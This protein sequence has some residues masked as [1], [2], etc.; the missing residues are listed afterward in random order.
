MCIIN[1]CLNMFRASLCSSSGEQRPCYCIWCVVLVLLDVVGS[2][3]QI[4]MKFDIWKFF[5]SLSGKFKF[6][7]NRTII[8]ATLNGGPATCRKV[9]RPAGMSCDRQEGPAVETTLR[10]SVLY[11]TSLQI[12]T[13]SVFPTHFSLPLFPP[14]FLV[15]LFVSTCL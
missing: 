2:N 13:R 14:L 7:F 15:I 9:L 1:F 11:G 5:E 12:V 6:H 8:A 3:Q 4:F 10:A